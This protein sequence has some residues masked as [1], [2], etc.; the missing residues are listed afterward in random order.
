MNIRLAAW[1]TS[2]R[3]STAGVPAS[4]PAPGK[5]RP[6]KAAFSTI[7]ARTS[8]TRRWR[9]SDEPA[10]VG[11]EVRR[12][13]DGEGANDSFTIRL[14]YLTGFSVTLGANCLSSLARPRFHL[15]GTSGNFWKW[16]L[17]PQE[18]ALE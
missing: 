12:E 4:R 14:H 17:D 16:G 13:R 7:S 2:N 15:R 10:S 1:F 18:D 8:S 6:T 9:S 11:A 5:K 3:T